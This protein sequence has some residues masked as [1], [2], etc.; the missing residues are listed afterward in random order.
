MSPAD[1]DPTPGAEPAAPA[2]PAAA[3]EAEAWAE[4]LAS[5]DDEARHRAYLARFPDLDGLTVAGRRYRAVLEARPG[6]ALAQRFRQEIVKRATVAGLAQLPRTPPP[7]LAKL[8][9][10][11]RILL[12][13]AVTS[14]VIGLVLALG[15]GIVDGL[16]ALWRR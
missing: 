1:L 14:L 3:G 12:V 11:A 15:K 7:A 13:I 2:A 5:W 8:P 16:G 10:L 9:R 4:V 6:D